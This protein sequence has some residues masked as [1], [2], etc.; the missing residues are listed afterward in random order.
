MGAFPS[1]VQTSLGQ[2]FHLAKQ[3]GQGGEGAIYEAREQTDLALKL[4]WPTKAESRREKISAMASAQ[5]YKTNSF[6]AFPIAIL[7]SP[8]GAFLGFVMR[9]VG[10]GKPVHLLFSPT[11]RKIEF[12]AA[13]YRFLVR[14]ASNIARAVASVHALSCVIGDVNHSGFLVSDKATTTLIDCDSFQILAA[15]KK[16]LCQVGTPEYTPPEL[17]GARFDRV[18]RSPN[19]DNFGLAVLLFQILFMGR[20]PFSGRYQ[21]SGESQRLNLNPLTWTSPCE[22]RSLTFAVNL[23][24]SF[25]GEW[26]PDLKYEMRFAF[27]CST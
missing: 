25:G 10:G 18:E 21:G 14:A 27:K 7:S 23:P 26:S 5:W 6:V 16:F 11:S 2:T 24:I 19:H 15:N 22:D 8:A 1:A 3:I 17:Q 13:D 4:Y 9:K 12:A 20:H